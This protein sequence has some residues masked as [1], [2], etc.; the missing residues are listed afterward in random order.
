M[1]EALTQA[2]RDSHTV[3]FRYDDM[4]RIVEPHAIGHTKAGKLVFRGFQPD[5]ET[6]RGL[7]WKLFSADKVTD[8]QV[9]PDA[10]F[11]AR[12]GYKMGDKQIAEILAQLQ[13]SNDG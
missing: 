10:P 1:I 4:I 5:G 3:T 9:V 13:V 8:L 2:V 7:G 6:Q 11:T 12:D